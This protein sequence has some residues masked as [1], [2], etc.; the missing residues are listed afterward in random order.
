MNKEKGKFGELAAEMYLVRKGLKVLTKNYHSRYGEIDIIASNE[1]CIVFVEVKLRKR[2][3]FCSGREA[4]SSS[5]K[6]RIL[7]TALVFLSEAKGEF[8]TRFDIIEI[9]NTEN[10]NGGAINDIVHLENAFT[11]NDIYNVA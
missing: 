8:N 10:I 5:K 3:C 2:R 9:Q 7:K 6:K 1:D 4:V 11:L